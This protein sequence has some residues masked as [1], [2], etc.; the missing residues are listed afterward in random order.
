MIITGIGGPSFACGAASIANTSIITPIHIKKIFDCFMSILLKIIKK[1]THY[2]I[3]Q[4]L[5]LI[6]I[7]NISDKNNQQQSLSA[8]TSGLC[9]NF[10]MN[11]S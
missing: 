9:S 5:L 6:R 11:I 10:S 2:K 1:Y 3:N 8:N 4:N 7:I